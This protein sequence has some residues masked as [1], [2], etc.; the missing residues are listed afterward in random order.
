MNL[1]RRTLL[2]LPIAWAVGMVVSGAAGDEVPKAVMAEQHFDVFEK[3]CLDCH[4]AD[5]EKGKVN[6]DELSFDLGDIESAELWQKIL[7]ALNSGEMPPEDKKQLTAEEKT[8]FLDD[9]SRQLVTARKIHS[10]T[11]GV[12]TMR[13]LNRRE[14]AN[15]MRELLAVEVDASELPDDANAGGFDTSGGALFFSSDQFERYGKIAR[16]ALDLAIVDAATKPELRKEHIEVELE[17]NK[18]VTGILR[19]YYMGGYRK[20]S[21]WKASKGRPPS[22]FGIADEQEMNFRKLSWDRNSPA[23]IDYLSAPETE[24]GALLTI[25]A[26]NPQV[27]AVIPDELPAGKYR[28]RVRIGAAPK[29]PSERTFVEIGFRGERPDGAMDVIACRKVSGSWNKPQVIEL[30]VDLAE[31]KNPLM[32]EIGSQ[33]KKKV[34]LGDRV[35]A[36]RERQQNS[37]DASQYRNSKAREAT[38][39]GEDPSLW[40]DWL[41]WEGPLVGEWPPE[42]HRRIFGEGEVDGTADSRARKII[43]DFATRAFRNKAPAASYV[44]KLLELFRERR[45]SGE[46]FAEAIKEPLS[47]VLSSPAFLYLAEPGGDSDKRGLSDL[48]LAVRLSYFLWSA[49]PDEELYGLARTGKISDPAVLTAQTNRMLNDPRSAEF[50]SGFAHQWL[51]MERLDFFQFN[52]RLYP[53]FDESV[54]ESARE[55]VYQTLALVVREKLGVGTLLKSDFVVINDLLADYYGIKGVSGDQFRKV[56]VPKELPRGGLLGMAAILAMGSDGERSSPVE[57]GAWVM[58]MLLHD[59]PPP[60]PANVP[61]IS[62]LAGKMLPARELLSAHMEEAQCAQCHRKIDPLGYGLENFDA[63]GRWRDLEYTEVAKGNRVLKTKE[64]PIDA[65]GTLPDGTA[66]DGFFELRDRIGD[67]ERA[68]SRGLAEALVEYGLGRPF[69]FSDHDLAEGIL[70]SAEGRNFEMREFIHALVQSEEFRRK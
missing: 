58:R 53:Q 17:A 25:G 65:S 12:I 37:F 24:I 41:E 6:L 23:F 19:G 16:E 56:P 15:T 52:H 47:V 5:T 62:R 68:F 38:G 60:A 13:R 61:Q 27:V 28:L 55:E 57:R 8:V 40:V 44:D 2:M 48:E 63:V 46:A 34:M 54:K 33:T 67:R 22:D 18:R 36:F 1:L 45:A 4:D 14:Y 39:F 50:I 3:Y 26:V 20:Y 59:P 21:Q 69:G 43:E 10:D 51:H 49:P 31:P 32:E 11:G 29:M 9:L 66:F 64:H 70:R 42:S 7:N 30:E 35:I